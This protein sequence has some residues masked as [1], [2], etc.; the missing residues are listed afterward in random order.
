MA[1]TAPTDPATA[2]DT[3][4]IIPGHLRPAARVLSSFRTG[5]A[6]YR[7]LMTTDDAV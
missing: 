1:R 4:H 6:K 5:Q 2:D 3:A 7:K